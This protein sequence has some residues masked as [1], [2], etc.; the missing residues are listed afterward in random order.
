MKP[1]KAVPKSQKAAGTGMGGMS[2]GDSI[3]QNGSSLTKYGIY[4][5]GLIIAIIV[6]HTRVPAEVEDGVIHKIE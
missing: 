1:I 3:L 2:P 6:I 5:G 4:S